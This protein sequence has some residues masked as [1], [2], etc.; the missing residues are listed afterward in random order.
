MIKFTV[1]RV[2][3]EHCDTGTE[4]FRVWRKPNRKQINISD[5]NITLEVLYHDMLRT[6]Y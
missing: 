1:W 6:T 4:V 5:D 3:P 2:H